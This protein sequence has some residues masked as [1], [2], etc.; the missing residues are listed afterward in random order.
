M[1]L[2]IIYIKLQKTLVMSFIDYLS[3]NELDDEY[4]KEYK[5]ECVRSN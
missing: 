5:Y 2:N 4:E 3:E 1:I